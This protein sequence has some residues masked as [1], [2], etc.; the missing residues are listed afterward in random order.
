M[1][2]AP[3]IF[4]LSLTGLLLAGCSGS[5]LDTGTLEGMVT[6]GPISPVEQLGEKP[7]IPPEVYEAKKVIV[8][9]SGG[10]RLIKEVELGQDGYYSTMLKPG[11]YMVDINHVGIDSSPVIPRKIEISSGETVELDIDIDT[12]IR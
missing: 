4:I 10:K 7:P 3:A 5:N 9:D 11:T 8:Y 2:K 12:G 1:R 6:I